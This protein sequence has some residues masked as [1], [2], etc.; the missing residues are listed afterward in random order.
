MGHHSATYRENVA[1]R[2]SVSG[3]RF[4]DLLVRRKLALISALLALCG[5]S[6]VVDIAT[7]PASLGFADVLSALFR[8]EQMAG[9]TRVIVRVMRLPIALMAIAAGANLGLA[10]A[11]MQTILT[12][13]LASPY[14]LGVGSGAAF[15]A[16]LAIV[17]GVGVIPTFGE[18]LVSVNAFFF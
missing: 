16:S 18:Y 17:A 9:N 14:T 4:Y 13:P 15:G 5:I 8:P 6:L 12:N 1:T 2:T 10:G 11:V 7:V 3:I